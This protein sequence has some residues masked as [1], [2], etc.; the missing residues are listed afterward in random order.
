MNYTSLKTNIAD[1]CENTFTDDQFALFAQQ[2]EQKIFNTVDLPVMRN[3][4]SGPLTATNK[5]YTT[6]D[7]YLYT[8]SLAIISSSTTNYVLNKDVNFLREAYPVNTSA[9]YGLPKFYAY[10]STSGN[11]I[12]LMFAPTPDQNYE[13]EHIYAKYPTS[14]VTAGGTYLGDN[15]DTA[16][17][18]GALVEAIRFM[19][20]EADMIALYEKHYL[21]AITL[22]KNASDGKLRQDVYRS[23]QVKN[24][25]S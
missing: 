11:K 3:V 10:H 24:P 14:I 25:V 13:I 5:L 21:Q 2:A 15:F 8:Y 7:G 4:D 12:K 1:I 23:G 16:L 6:P 17:L 18:N 9:K 20:G 22:L 19:K